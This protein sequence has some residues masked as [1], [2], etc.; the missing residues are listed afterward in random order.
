ML[1]VFTATYNEYRFEIFYLPPLRDF[2]LQMVVPDHLAAGGL[3]GPAVLVREIK[4]HEPV[5]IN[6]LRQRLQFGDLPAVQLD[7]LV[8]TSEKARYQ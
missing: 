2:A 1:M 5:V 8:D 7:L 6:R 4:L 3:V